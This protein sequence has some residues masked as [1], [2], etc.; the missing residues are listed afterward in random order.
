[1]GPP[2]GGTTTA[3]LQPTVARHE[4]VCQPSA[5]PPALARSWHARSE[6][7]VRQRRLLPTSRRMSRVAHES[8]GDAVLAATVGAAARLA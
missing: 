3:L 7:P 1:M 8:R 2:T 5:G 4:A 6:G